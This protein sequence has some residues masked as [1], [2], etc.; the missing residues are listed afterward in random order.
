MERVNFAIFY[1]DP[2]CNF[3]P[4][5][6]FKNWGETFETIYDQILYPTDKKAISGQQISVIQ[7]FVLN[8]VAQ[9]K[10]IRGAGI[11]HS[12]GKVFADP[13]Q[14]L[15]SFYPYKVAK[16]TSRVLEDYAQ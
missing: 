1:H 3:D 14:C 4:A 11:R 16:G 10:K 5:K 6:N 13:N 9:G 2:C 15:V 12:W 7:D 8:K